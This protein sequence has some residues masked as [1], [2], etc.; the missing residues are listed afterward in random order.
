M[1]AN[2]ETL[3]TGVV[4]KG[5]NPDAGTKDF[6]F[7]VFETVTANQESDDKGESIICKC[8]Y[9]DGESIKVTRFHFNSGEEIPF[10]AKCTSVGAINRI[11]S[12]LFNIKT[13]VAT[14]EQKEA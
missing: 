6:C 7:L 13:T 10:T 5:N 3:K 8:L 14:M 1:I 4:I 12:M 2:D 9:L 11:K